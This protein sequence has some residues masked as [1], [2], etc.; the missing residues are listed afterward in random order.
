VEGTARIDWALLPQTFS[1]NFTTS[2]Q[3]LRRDRRETDILSNRERRNIFSTGPTFSYRASSVDTVNFAAFYTDT[4]FKETETSDNSRLTGNLF[5]GHKLPRNRE[6]TAGVSYTETDFDDV[7]VPDI[8]RTSGYLSYASSFSNTQ[9][10]VKAGLNESK[11]DASET[12]DGPLFE[13][14]INY[15]SGNQELALVAINQ[16]TDST[17]GLG[18]SSSIIDG[19]IPDSDNNFADIDIVE[20]SHLD[21][22]Y[23]NHAVCSVCTLSGFIVYD[24]QDFN[25]L[26]NDEESVQLGLGF[27]YKFTQNLNTE[28]SLSRETVKFFSTDRKDD[29]DRARLRIN[30]TV[31]PPLT[32]YLSL[33]N[34]QRS[35]NLATANYDELRSGLGFDYRF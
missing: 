35:S 1:W 13:A 28:L 9:W 27:A 5:W 6:F 18:D 19:D 21:I 12:V 3:D 16:I 31:L 2:T 4:S 17:I 32:L 24:D 20:R 14:T 7:T 15:Q 25:K 11:Q 22:R 10:S 26:N 30:Y 34:E 23:T 29:V 33:H 8:E